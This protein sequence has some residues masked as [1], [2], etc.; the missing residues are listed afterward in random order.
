MRFNISVDGKKVGRQIER[1]IEDGIENAADEITR[2]IERRAKSHIRREGAIWRYHLIESFEDATLEFGDRTV[3]SVRN[4]SGHASYQERGVSGTEIKRD[5]PHAYTDK[6][7]PVTELIPWVRAHLLGTGFDP[8]YNPNSGSKGSS[9]GSDSGGSGGQDRSSGGGSSVDTTDS[10]IPTDENGLYDPEA[11]YR[12]FDITDSFLPENTFPGQEIVVYDTFDKK[13]RRADLVS[14]PDEGDKHIE[15]KFHDDGGV[16]HVAT[17]NDGGFKLAGGQ[18][19]DSLTTPEKKQKLRDHF[20]NEIRDGYKDYPNLQKDP[21]LDPPTKDRLDWIIDKWLDELWDNYRDDWNIKETFRNYSA[22]FDVGKSAR[23]NNILGGVRPQSGSTRFVLSLWN[24]NSVANHKHV[25]ESYYTE[26]LRHE[27]LHAHTQSLN[28]GTTMNKAIGW[29]DFLDNAKWSRTGLN[30]NVY[31]DMPPHAD[32]AM[33]TDFH[34]GTKAD[35][36]GGTDWIGDA[37]DAAMK[38][39]SGIENYSP[40]FG[41]PEKY[42][43]ERMLEAANLAWWLQSVAGSD[44]KDRGIFLKQDDF[45]ITWGYS[46]YNAEETLAE[47]HELLTGNH[48]ST[49]KILTRLEFLKL[50]YP[51][52]VNAWLG[53]YKP[54]A[55]QAYILEQLG[56]SV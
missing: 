51:W 11:N 2:G 8:D 31:P 55:R 53:V 36:V 19:W 24:R 16:T 3:A 5:T 12:E 18:F 9:S 54:S 1:R 52:L 37:Y 35:P 34:A 44:S 47:L 15:V 25:T 14:Y 13:Y 40:T 29:E 17:T 23:N 56:F 20:D 26:V 28:Y 27:S 48:T 45:F 22:G 49:S 10:G 43:Y 46:S 30:H 32:K 7:P 38:G 50:H 6:K 41:T 21:S 42:K 4:I 33:F 39:P